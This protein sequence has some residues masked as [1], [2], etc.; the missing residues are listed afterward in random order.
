M[1]SSQ[2]FF[3]GFGNQCY[4]CVDPCVLDI[5]ISRSTL[6]EPEVKETQRISNLSSDACIKSECRSAG[7]WNLHLGPPSS[8][9]YSSSI[10]SGCWLP[11]TPESANTVPTSWSGLSVDELTH[12]DPCAFST[13]SRY[14]KMQFC[15]CTPLLKYHVVNCGLEVYCPH[16]RWGLLYKSSLS[17]ISEYLSSYTI[18]FW[19]P[20]TTCSSLRFLVSC[21]S[22]VFCHWNAR[23]PC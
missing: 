16:G 1:P 14:F 19:P 9:T 7:I 18:L 3:V 17:V 15:L 4:L 22:P 13:L 11:R 5:L 8:V 2:H 6:V 21:F 10:H 20:W 23:V 12:H